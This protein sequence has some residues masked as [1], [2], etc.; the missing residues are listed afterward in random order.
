MTA[1]GNSKKSRKFPQC[2]A[3]IGLD[4]ARRASLVS[5]HLRPRASDRDSEAGPSPF[6]LR[7]PTNRSRKRFRFSAP[8]GPGPFRGPFLPAAAWPQ[9]LWNV[10][11]RQSASAR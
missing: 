2:T 5:G 4:P 9:S 10:P 6:G 7:Q 3:G 11:Q 1:A 8:L